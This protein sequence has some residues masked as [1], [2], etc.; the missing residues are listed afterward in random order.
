MRKKIR[1]QR[2]RLLKTFGKGTGLR[3]ALKRA[4]KDKKF[5]RRDA[6]KLTI[7]GANLK[8]LEK[9]RRKSNRLS[10]FKVDNKIN[11]PGRLRSTF[12]NTN[13]KRFSDDTPIRDVRF[14]DAPNTSG[15]Y[16]RAPE[17]ETTPG[18]GTGTGAGSGSG[19]P[20]AAEVNDELK[21]AALDTDS[22]PEGNLETLATES[23][24]AGD[25]SGTLAE[26]AAAADMTIEQF[27]EKMND[28]AYRMRVKGIRFADRG[29]GGMTRSQLARRG[30]TGVF[31]RS[32]LRIQSLNI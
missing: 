16:V 13:D 15:Q 19:T 26:Q 32:G 30:T 9:I 27:K 23:K 11:T 22:T 6:K 5:N 7:K 20:T 18:T 17:K 8:Q 21:I 1:R 4:L 24:F 12:R 14:G 31:G 28:P 2:K 3:K 25:M 10:R 29:T